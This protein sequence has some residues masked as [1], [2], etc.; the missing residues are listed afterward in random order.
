MPIIVSHPEPTFAQYEPHRTIDNTA[1]EYILAFPLI[2][3]L[4]LALFLR[5]WR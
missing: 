3:A 4:V 1:V 2:L 5:R